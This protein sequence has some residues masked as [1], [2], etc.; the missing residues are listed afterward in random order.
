MIRAFGAILLYSLLPLLVCQCRCINACISFFKDN[1]SKGHN[2]QS[3]GMGAGRTLTVEEFIAANAHRNL[4]PELLRTRF[5]VADADKD[6]LLTPAEVD[7]HRAR[8]AERK[9]NAN[10]G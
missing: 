2:L 1:A 3:G 7:S 9:R 5:R 6:G 4:P 8:A 10:P